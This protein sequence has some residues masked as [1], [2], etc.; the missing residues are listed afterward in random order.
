MCSSDLN[1]FAQALHVLKKAGHQLDVVVGSEG[2]GGFIR[3]Q[4]PVSSVHYRLSANRWL[5]LLNFMLTQSLIFWKVLHLC[6]RH[7]AD[8]VYVNTVLPVGAVLAG[9]L[10]RRRV[11]VHAHEVGLGSRGLFRLLRAVVSKHANTIVC[12]SEYVARELAWPANKAVVV[13]N[14]LSPKD[15]EA[16]VGIARQQLAPLRHA[17][18][19]TVVM[20]CSL[21][22]YKGLDSFVELARRLENESGNPDFR[23]ELLL[24]CAPAEFEEFCTGQDLPS[25]LIAVR[26]PPSVY[27][28]YR[29]ADLVL[30][31]SHPEGWIET[32]GL[33]LLEAMAC[34]VPVISPTVGGC[35]ELF[36]PGN[37]GWRIASRDMDSL[38]RLIEHLATNPQ[39]HVVARQQALIAAQRFSPDHFRQK[40][41]A[42]FSAVS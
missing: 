6:L 22:W 31:L 34:A 41:E 1:V 21:R 2:E 24:N 27:R 40:L 4:H 42:V 18:P 32:F 10:C 7:R 35:T 38:V 12:V 20:A 28:H 25:N 26:N 30:N 8:M 16:A 36:E 5:L 14:A 39:A 15:W 19:F 9:A 13:Y 11:V 33:T 37:G 29:H 17:R 3:S 23:F